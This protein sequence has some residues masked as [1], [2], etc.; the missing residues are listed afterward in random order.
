MCSSLC[1]VAA[2]WCML[3]WYSDGRDDV[4]RSVTE[5]IGGGGYVQMVAPSGLRL[6]DRKGNNGV[7]TVAIDG[8]AELIPTSMHTLDEWGASGSDSI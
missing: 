1:Y 3:T 7:G 6:G 2:T 4:A 5:G 8:S